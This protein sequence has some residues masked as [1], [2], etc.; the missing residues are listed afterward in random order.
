M[1]RHPANSPSEFAVLEQAA[2][3]FAL[4]NADTVAQDDRQRWLHWM[5]ESP[6]HQ[7]AWAKVEAIGRQF[8]QLA[9][10]PA[11]AALDAAGH[12][13]RR[14]IG[15]LALACV[16]G[17]AAFSGSRSQTFQV[18]T[19]GYRTGI[20]ET[21]HFRMADGTQLWLNTQSA[22]NADYTRTFRTLS[23][24]QGEILIE[25][26]ADTAMPARPLV[27]DTRHGRLRALGTRFTVRDGPDRTLLSVFEG[28]VEIHPAA[29]GEKTRIVQAGEQ[30]YFDS[31]EIGSTQAADLARQ[32]WQRGMLLAD[33]MRL[34]DFISELSRY[35]HGHIG[36]TPE[37]AGLRLVGAY[38][39]HD[40][41][42]VLAALEATLPVQVK[43]TLPWWITIEPRPEKAADTAP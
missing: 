5:D 41:E 32:S 39:L 25:S 14:A 8:G 35:R 33:N 7:L 36:C 27:V 30:A 11:R 17:M 1:N 9:P 6:T 10:E 4:L 18:W 16:T 31:Q 43:R 19:A 12:S 40:T 34:D 13:R 2:E 20:G 29:A 21:R 24:V 15:L 26:A 22:A 23:L 3:W 42:R 28:A 38:P 37:V